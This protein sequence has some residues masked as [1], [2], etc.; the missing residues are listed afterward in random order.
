MRRTTKENR[1]TALHESAHAVIYLLTGFDLTEVVV[2]D[3]AKQDGSRPSHFGITRVKTPGTD[4][5]TKPS[6]NAFVNALYGKLAG[7]IA[8]ELLT[9]DEAEIT[10]EHF[11]RFESLEPESFEPKSDMGTARSVAEA[12]HLFLS[13]NYK[14]MPA[15]V[16]AKFGVVG[17]KVPTSREILQNAIVETTKMVIENWDLIHKVSNKLCSK[18]RLTGERV[19]EICNRH[20]ESERKKDERKKAA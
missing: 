11:E 14:S 2:Y 12:Q 15:E 9:F 19:V 4:P 17:D 1:D 6:L 7:P 5:A 8:T 10:L 3:D 16:Q 18:R 20:F 13:E